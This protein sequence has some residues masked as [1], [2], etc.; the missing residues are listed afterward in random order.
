M[1]TRCRITRESVFRCRGPAAFAHASQ[2]SRRVPDRC[3][4]FRET[5]GKRQPPDMIFTELGLPG[6]PGSG[7]FNASLATIIGGQP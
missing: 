1:F 2:R 6:L 4:S 7:N 3:K 5:F